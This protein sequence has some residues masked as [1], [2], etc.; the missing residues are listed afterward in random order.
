MLLRAEV[1]S[2]LT[3]RDRF[4]DVDVLG[5]A[6]MSAAN[7]FIH[8]CL[9]RIKYLNDAAEIEAAKR[10]FIR[11]ARVAMV[12]RKLNPAGASRMGVQALVAWVNDVCQCC[13]GHGYMPIP[14][15]PALS[16]YPCPM[17]GTTGK[18]H[19]KVK[20][21]ELEVF[22]DVHSRADAAVRIVEVGLDY[23]LWSNENF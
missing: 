12:N 10:V 20:G 17:C 22:M 4:S 8:T 1:S 21:Q 7:Q 19:T 11:W 23:N 5:A 15:A 6:G 18:H 9:Y 14:G 16:N 2:D 13:G 3:H